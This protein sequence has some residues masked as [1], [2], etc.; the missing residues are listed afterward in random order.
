MF[1]F[2]GSRHAWHLHAA[3]KQKMNIFDCAVCVWESENVYVCVCVRE[4]ESVRERDT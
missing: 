4:R 2:V 3:N 1:C